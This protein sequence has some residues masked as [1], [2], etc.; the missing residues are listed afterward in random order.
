MLAATQHDLCVAADYMLL[1][2][3][4]MNTARD[5]VRWHL[6]DRGNR[7][8]WSS[9]TP[10]LD[11]ANTAN[12]QVIWSLFH[13]G[14]PDDLDVFRPVFVD[15]FARYCGAVAR[16]VRDLSD[17]VPVYNP[18]SEI[19]FFAWAAA[20]TCFIYPCAQGRA[21]EVKR[22]LVR[23]AIAGCEAIWEVDARA[24]MV[25]ADPMVQVI[26]PADRADLEYHARI[27]HDA[28]FEAWDMLCGQNQP[29]LGGHPKYLDLIGI[30]YY[31]DNQRELERRPLSWEDR[32]MS[33]DTRWHSVACQ[34]ANVHERYGRPLLISET[35]HFGAGRGP[36]IRMIANQVREAILHRVPVQGICLYP[37][38]DRP[39]WHN[40]HHWHNSGLYDL[41]P[42]GP[43]LERV[44]NEMYACDLEKAQA[45]FEREV[46][47]P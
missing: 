19:S 28:Q 12:V 20:E 11:A 17:A 7:F 36:W 43:R 9:L 46:A 13:Y 22:Q 23:A 38:L 33:G 42:N 40:P 5:A 29:E 21:A 44:L 1:R 41:R 30:N 4:G 27:Q 24:R 34:L 6:V 47:A 14:I 15:R 37:F 3:H 32:M 45:L 16:L 31:H 25:H 18:I 10:M 2:A 8:D 39:D 26:A 35:S